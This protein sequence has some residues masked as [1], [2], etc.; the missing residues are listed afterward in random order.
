MNLRPAGRTVFESNTRESDGLIVWGA[1]CDVHVIPTP[2]SRPK[3]HIRQLLTRRY[4]HFIMHE[5]LSRSEYKTLVEQAPIMIWRANTSAKC[6]YFNDRWLRFRGR[7]MEQ[8]FGDQWAEGVHPEDL[9][10]CVTTYLAA[11]ENREAFEMHYRLLRSDG[12][13]RWILDRGAPFFGERGDFQGYIG[14]CIDITA[15][16]EAQHALDEAHERELANLRGLLP[17][18]MVCKKI[19]DAEG[20]WHQIELFISNHSQADFTHGMCPVCEHDLTR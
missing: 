2:L 13:Y 12:V 11:F 10:A 20:N 3:T 6:D 14:S 1:T 9:Q 5:E 8:E 16:I 7:T 17:I 15:R 19:R 18:C 4:D